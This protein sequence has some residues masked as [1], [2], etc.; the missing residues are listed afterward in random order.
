M[1]RQQLKDRVVRWAKGG[2]SSRLPLDDIFN[3]AQEMIVDTVH[4]LDLDTFVDF[5]PSRAVQFNAQVWSH[6]LPA[7]FVDA[8]MVTNNQTRLRSKRLDGLVNDWGRARRDYSGENRPAYYTV[9]GLALLTAPG[10]GGDL[11]MGYMARD[12]LTP[13]DNQE[14]IVMG[15]YPAVYFWAM[16]VG[17]QTFYEN[18]VGLGIA[19]RRFEAERERINK[20][21][22]AGRM[23][24]GGRAANV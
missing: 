19:D 6:P 23:G 4:P 13:D 7:D 14:N 17:A 22:A 5:D 9:S 12:A 3:D 8:F 21:A 18:E 10:Q 11:R 2:S 20:T 16:M 15:K 24:A 1:N